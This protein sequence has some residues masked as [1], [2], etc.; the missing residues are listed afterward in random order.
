MR[1]LWIEERG[2][3]LLLFHEKVFLLYSEEADAHDSFFSNENVVLLF[4]EST[5][6]SMSSSLRRSRRRHVFLIT[7][8]VA[9]LFNEE[10]CGTTL[11]VHEKAFLILSEEAGTHISFFLNGKVLLLSN[12]EEDAALPLFHEKALLLLNDEAGAS[13]SFFLDEKVAP[14]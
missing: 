9:L 7:W 14:L 10:K 2:V 3:T 11:L 5:S 4:N 1:L 12:E 6:D 8:E 13:T